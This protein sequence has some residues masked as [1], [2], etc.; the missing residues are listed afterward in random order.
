MWSWTA[1]TGSHSTK[2]PCRLVSLMWTATWLH[3]ILIH[4]LVWQLLLLWQCLN[5]CLSTGPCCSTSFEPALFIQPWQ[6]AINSCLMILPKQEKGSMP[7]SQ[8]LLLAALLLSRWNKQN[9]C[10][11][12]FFFYTQICWE[13]LLITLDLNTELREHAWCSHHI[14]FIAT[15]F[16]PAV[17]AHLIY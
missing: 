4:R 9:F 11:F 8:S 10:I 5:A 14:W 3:H 1:H 2:K 15:I 7:K 12:F 6:S 16:V 13:F 17:C